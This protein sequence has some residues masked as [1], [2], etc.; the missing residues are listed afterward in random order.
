[1]SFHSVADEGDFCFIN[2]YVKFK[3]WRNSKSELTWLGVDTLTFMFA[4]SGVIQINSFL[5]LKHKKK[6]KESST[7]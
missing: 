5:V 6:F 2:D 3:G 7:L 1:M 4:V